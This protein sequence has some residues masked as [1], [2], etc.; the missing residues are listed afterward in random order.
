MSTLSFSFNTSLISESLRDEFVKKF[1]SLS[2]EYQELTSYFPS[3]TSTIPDASEIPPPSAFVPLSDDEE[4]LDGGASQVSA[5]GR[6][7]MIYLTICTLHH[8]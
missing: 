2:L 7:W 3:L 8:T 4:E 5:A 6:S 1:F